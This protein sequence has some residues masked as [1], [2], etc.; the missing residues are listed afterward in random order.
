ML[1]VKKEHP[2]RVGCKRIEGKKNYFV[3][4]LKHQAKVINLKTIFNNKQQ[5]PCSTTWAQQQLVYLVT[6]FWE[7][8]ISRHKE[9][10]IKLIL[11]A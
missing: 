6:S 3:V 7:E 11:K 2:K 10:S 4:T 8:Y 5:H 1:V 9:G